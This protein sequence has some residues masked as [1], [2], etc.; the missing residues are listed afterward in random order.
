MP[1]N[2]ATV[3]SIETTLRLHAESVIA[4]LLV[5]THNF[6]LDQVVDHA[7]MQTGASDAVKVTNRSSGTVDRLVA[8]VTRAAYQIFLNAVR[9]LQP[10]TG[11]DDRLNEKGRERVSHYCHMRVRSI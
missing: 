4:D 8:D 6:T 2:T 5:A 1:D 10:T 3:N 9:D 11:A 7:W